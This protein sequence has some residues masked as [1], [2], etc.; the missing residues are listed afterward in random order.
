MS[1]QSSQ[2]WHPSNHACPDPSPFRPMRSECSFRPSKANRSISQ[3]GTTLDCHCCAMSSV[4]RVW[5]RGCRY[6]SVSRIGGW[7]GTASHFGAGTARA[8]VRAAD[9]EI[10]VNALSVAEI[11]E[12]TK[13][14]LKR[15]WA[16]LASQASGM[17]AIGA[18]S[19]GQRNGAGE[20]CRQCA[21]GV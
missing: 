14:E 5:L 20:R 12:R 17:A 15:F 11:Q 13:V 3:M 21:S 10:A 19:E 1:P 2:R 7:K 16:N 8:A 18:S 4:L 6:F 9:R